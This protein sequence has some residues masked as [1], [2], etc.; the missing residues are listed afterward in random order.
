MIKDMMYMRCK[1]CGKNMEKIAVGIEGAKNKAVSY[2]CP[3]GH[4]EFEKASS[5]MIVKELKLSEK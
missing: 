3:S 4:I 1:K 5:S 2:Q